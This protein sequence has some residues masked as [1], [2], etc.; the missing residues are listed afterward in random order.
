MGLDCVILLLV[1][2]CGSNWHLLNFIPR[3]NFIP[4]QPH[5]RR[6]LQGIRQEGQQFIS[7]HL[8][9]SYSKDALVPFW[10]LEKASSEAV[11][12]R[13]AQGLWA[14]L[15]V[16]FC[17]TQSWLNSLQLPTC[18]ALG[19]PLSPRCRDV[20]KPSIAGGHQGDSVHQCLLEPSPPV[21]LMCL[22]IGSS[23]NSK[24]DCPF[25]PPGWRQGPFNP[26]QKHSLLEKVPW[27]FLQEDQR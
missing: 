22:T 24:P 21:C 8:Q 9:G 17:A 10:D 23:Q 11:Y 1:Q 13:G 25:P 12:A 3:L 2:H 16:G 15:N 26:S 14:R 27:I 5:L 18:S 4:H 19:I 6:L 7:L 20:F